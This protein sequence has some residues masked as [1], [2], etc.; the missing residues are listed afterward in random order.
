MH[1]K[2]H[3]D[4]CLDTT[5]LVDDNFFDFEKLKAS[6]LNNLLSWSFLKKISDFSQWPLACIGTFF[7]NSTKASVES[8]NVYIDVNTYDKRVY[9][10]EN[11]Q[12]GVANKDTLNNLNPRNI[13]DRTIV[14]SIIDDGVG[15]SNSD[16]NRIMFS[17][18]INENVEYNF[19]KNGLSLKTAAIRLANSFVILTKTVESFSIGMISKNLQMKANTDFVLTPIVN[20]LIKDSILTPVSNYHKNSLSLILS[21]IKFIFYD[22]NQLKD[23]INSFETGIKLIKHI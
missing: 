12:K 22:E 21:E 1:H 18:S 2:E 9:Q 20:Y 17:Y 14:L 5:D 4:Q 16:F 11:L 19:F 10:L 8:K 6:Y 7:E 13:D 15:I 23:Y 3:K